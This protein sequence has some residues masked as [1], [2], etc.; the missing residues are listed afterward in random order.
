MTSVIWEAIES[1]EEVSPEEVVY[2]LT[3]AE[4]HVFAVNDGLVVHNTYT[5]HTPLVKPGDTIKPG[6]LLAKSNYVD[7]NGAIA[8]GMNA[9]AAVMS[10]GGEN[11]M[12]SIA[13]SQSFA[14]RM[15]SQHAYQNRVDFSDSVK[16]GKKVFVSSFPGTYVK[17]Q[18]DTI[19]DNGIVQVGT[20]V[21]KGDPLVLSA[22]VNSKPVDRIHRKGADS[23]MNTA[24]EWD[25][26]DPGVVTDVEVDKNGVNVVVSS[27]QPMRLG[28]KMSNRFG[29]K[30]VVSA[31]IPDDQMPQSPEG[32]VEVLYSPIGNIGRVNY[33]M[34]AEHLLGRI[35]KKTGKPIKIQSFDPNNPDTMKYVLELAKQ[36][37][38][39]PREAL[40]D[41][42]TGKSIGGVDG[43]GVG[44]GYS[45]V[46]KL[47]HSAE[48]KADER[49]F[50]RYT[51]DDQPACLQAGSM[52]L[53]Q[54]GLVSIEELVNK[55]TTVWTGYNWATA[56]GVNMGNHQLAEIE[57]EN[58]TIIHCDI[59]HKLQN[60]YGEWVEFDDLKIGMKVAVYNC[61][62]S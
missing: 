1:I 59:R 24:L 11:S 57:L 50:G 22:T 4:S 47:H 34:I 28:D 45:Y 48:G 36:H 33:S 35:A 13:V 6:Q 8:Q 7:D 37:G 55:E 26:D 16:T 42:N 20:K 38:I 49:S 31:I 30:G 60:E 58:G 23:F 40:I 43:Q 54:D 46:Q 15:K 27:L 17:E 10:W 44:F 53:T 5:S 2:D 32:P 41:P 18:L 56:S 14:D 39:N 9:R 21:I 3:V 61:E 62:E 25:H 51:A 29:A 52:V 19:G 12:D